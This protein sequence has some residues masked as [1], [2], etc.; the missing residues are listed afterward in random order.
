MRFGGNG[1]KFGGSRMRFG[2]SLL[3]RLRVCC[4]GFM[5]RNAQHSYQNHSNQQT[6][7]VPR[8]FCA[9][10]ECLNKT[11]GTWLFLIPGKQRGCLGPNLL[12]SLA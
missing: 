9:V 2:G 3:R 6:C 10:E 4:E 1:I 5:Y 8:V 12:R 7:Q 11:R